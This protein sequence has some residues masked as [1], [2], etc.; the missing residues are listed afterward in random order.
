MLEPGARGPLV[1]GYLLAS[2]TSG[3]ASRYRLASPLICRERGWVQVAGA[4]V[5]SYDIERWQ[6]QE[7]PHRHPVTRSLTRPGP[8]PAPTI[9]IA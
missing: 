7:A 4:F 6:W 1:W 8:A 9:A 2:A 5:P 3:I